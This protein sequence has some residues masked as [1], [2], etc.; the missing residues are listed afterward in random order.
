VDIY[1]NKRTSSLLGLL[2]YSPH[3]PTN[4][5]Q[6]ANGKATLRFIGVPVENLLYANS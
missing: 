6:T 1:K 5:P 2:D 4:K 3:P